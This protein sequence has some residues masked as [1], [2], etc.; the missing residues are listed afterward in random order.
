MVWSGSTKGNIKGNIHENE[1]TGNDIIIPSI[2]GKDWNAA[3]KEAVGR[4]CKHAK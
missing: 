2:T 4:G 3:Y 1:A